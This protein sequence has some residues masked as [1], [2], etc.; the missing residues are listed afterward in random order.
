M[1]T[2]GVHRM[3]SS[4]PLWAKA[5]LSTAASIVAS[6]SVGMLLGWVG[7]QVGL[8]A[9]VAWTLT[10]LAAVVV[11]A[12]FSLRLPQID[13]ETS[14]VLLHLGPGWWALINGGLLGLGFTSR[15]GFWGW[16]LLPITAFASASV[17][18]GGAIWATYGATRL[19]VTAVV[20]MRMQRGVSEAI[21]GRPGAPERIMLKLAYARPTVVRRLRP[22]T[23][24]FAVVL[25]LIWGLG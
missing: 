4:W 17:A 11:G 10:L 23:S 20:A 19:A 7:E 1:A 14:Q 3:K 15:I 21:P 2:S 5:A 25:L 24:L 8:L 13:R 16:Y 22:A 18:Y 12:S 6:S 9:R